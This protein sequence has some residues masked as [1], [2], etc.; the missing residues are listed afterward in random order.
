MG[1]QTGMGF[2]SRKTA[3]KA[4]APAG[5]ICALA[6]MVFMA[7]TGVRASPSES[8]HHS[9]DGFRNIYPD[10]EEERG[11][12]DFFKWQWERL[13]KDIPGP[14]EYDFS[15]A[16][17]DAE[18]LRN[19]TDSYTVTWIG[20]ATVLVQMDGKNILT[21]PHFTER[22]SPVSWAGP[23]RVVPPGI[24]LSELPRIHAVVISHDH[25]D[26]LDDRSIRMLR[27]RPGGEDTVFFVP[28]GLKDMFKGL[29]VSRVEEMD[30]WEE[31]RHDGVTVAAV[32]VQHWSKRAL[33]S[34]NHTLWAGWII[35]SERF[36]FFFVGDSG[37]SPLFREIGRTYG[38]FDLAAIPI[39]AYEPR[40]FMKKHH[41]NPEESVQVH[42]D[43][44]SKK[45][46]AIH[47]GTFI[48]TDERL[49]EPPGRLRQAAREQ[50]LPEDAFLILRHGE[51]VLLR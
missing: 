18:F 19:N 24:P 8:P 37:Y 22:A 9:E 13:W 26:S 12:L 47:W 20:H 17:N 32:P 50:G 45:S 35:R 7:G 29:G 39:G 41:M 51:T 33:S 15:L 16:E 5:V 3:V 49:D 11:A 46:V 10:R 48:L 27:E 34:R 6:V 23:E 40:W 36:R 4:T 30:W 38:P 44:R 28:F 42:L 25:Y 14:E 1:G 31:R 2:M 21:D 43:I